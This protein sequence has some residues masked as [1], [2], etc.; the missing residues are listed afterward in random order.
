MA[1]P[2]DI[3]A[4]TRASMLRMGKTW[5]Q[6]G[7]LNQAVETFLRIV[8]EH[9]DTREAESAQSNLLEIAQGFEGEGRY[10]LALDILDRLNK[11]AGAVA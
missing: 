10:H 5:Y 9:P 2:V 1:N 8:E 6:L 3:T 7:K 4:A 11:V